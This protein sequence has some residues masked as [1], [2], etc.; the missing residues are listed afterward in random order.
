MF[1]EVGCVALKE[2]PLS[3]ENSKSTVTYCTFVTLR[4]VR[5]ITVG[6]ELTDLVD[7]NELPCTVTQLL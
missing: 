7:K 5:D 6:I 4:Y 2:I 1:T 3:L